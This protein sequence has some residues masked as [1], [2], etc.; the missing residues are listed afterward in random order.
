M[1]T[2]RQRVDKGRHHALVADN[3]HDANAI[4][5]IRALCRVHST[6]AVFRLTSVHAA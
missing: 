2:F 6:A 1:L 3:A 5:H 4:E